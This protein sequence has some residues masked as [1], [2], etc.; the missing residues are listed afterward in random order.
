M[1]ESTGDE[2]PVKLVQI[3]K[4]VWSKTDSSHRK[5]TETFQRNTTPPSLSPSVSPSHTYAH[6]PPFA[7]LG[8]DNNGSW[9]S[10]DRRLLTLTALCYATN[11]W[12]S[13][14]PSLLSTLLTSRVLRVNR[15]A[16]GVTRGGWRARGTMTLSLCAPAAFVHWSPARRMQNYFTLK[17]G[18]NHFYP[19][20]LTRSWHVGVQTHSGKDGCVIIRTF[21]F[22]KRQ[23]ALKAKPWLTIVS[24]DNRKDVQID[25]SRSRPRRALCIVSVSN[26]S[27][28]C[29]GRRYG[30]KPAEYKVRREYFLNQH[31]GYTWFN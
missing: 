20:N 3:V 31:A 19:I 30:D 12:L 27:P 17:G 8:A 14:R 2:G 21:L 4:N 24:H 22:R 6:T 5:S 11:V 9:R 10:R 1:S 18:F 29:H 13:P 16:A 23:I 25:G 28:G 15:A 26:T 7:G